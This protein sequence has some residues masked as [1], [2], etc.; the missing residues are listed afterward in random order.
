MKTDSSKQFKMQ[1]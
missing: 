1:L